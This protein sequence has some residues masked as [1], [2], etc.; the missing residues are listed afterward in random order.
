M[1]LEVRLRRA[2]GTRSSYT[3]GLRGLVSLVMELKP[4]V[5]VADLHSIVVVTFL[6]V[7]C[8][9]VEVVSFIPLKNDR[10]ICTM[11]ANLKPL[12]APLLKAASTDGDTIPPEVELVGS[13][14]HGLL[15][16]AGAAQALSAP[17][18]PGIISRNFQ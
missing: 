3:F 10:G 9:K 11:L 4:G 1:S 15:Q 17:I 12:Q 13:W 7:V 5:R 8:G 16:P 6:F 14:A 18:R 2:D